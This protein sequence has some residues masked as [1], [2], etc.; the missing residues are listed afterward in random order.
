MWETDRFNF[1]TY[2]CFIK[3]LLVLWN[4]FWKCVLFSNSQSIFVRLKFCLPWNFHRNSPEGKHFGLTFDSLNVKG[5]SR[6]SNFSLLLFM[7]YIWQNFLLFSK[8]SNLFYL[9]FFLQYLLIFLKVSSTSVLMP[10]FHSEYNVIF[11]S[12]DF[13]DWLLSM[14]SSWYTSFQTSFFIIVF[15]NV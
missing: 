5:I 12:F 9:F 2:T 14:C 7:S 6:L 11:L 1:L 13:F 10:L 15:L 8:F 3:V 4:E